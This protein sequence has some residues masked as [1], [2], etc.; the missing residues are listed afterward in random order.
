VEE[1]KF[2]PERTEAETRLEKILRLEETDVNLFLYATGAP[3]YEPAKDTGYSQLLSKAL[4]EAVRQ[5]AADRDQQ[6]CGGE[7]REGQ[8]CGLGFDPFICSDDHPQRYEFRTI[9]SDQSSAIIAAEWPITYRN[10][11]CS[12][13]YRMVKE[14]GNWKLDGIDTRTGHTFNMQPVSEARK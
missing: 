11:I 5:Q 6:N 2:H 8:I 9:T 10:S 14:K 1:S 13:Y 7:Y 4:V 12:R 3:W